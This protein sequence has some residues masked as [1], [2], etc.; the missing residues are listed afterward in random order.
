MISDKVK[1]KKRSANEV[2][3]LLGEL[4]EKERAYYNLP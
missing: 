1:K 2:R 3:D 4:L